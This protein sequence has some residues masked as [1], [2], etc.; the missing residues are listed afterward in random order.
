MRQKYTALEL[1]EEGNLMEPANLENTERYGDKKDGQKSLIELAGKETLYILKSLHEGKLNKNT[2]K[3]EYQYNELGFKKL[4]D[5]R[6]TWTNTVRAIGGIQDAQEQYDKLVEESKTNAQIKQ[7]VDTKIANPENSTNQYEFQAT[8]AI[9]QDFSKSRIPYIQLTVF[10]T[11]IGEKEVPDGYYGTKLIDVFEYSTA[12]TDASNDVFNVIRK[13]QE[14]FKASTTNLY[15][16]RIGR[17]NIPTLNLQK[18]VDAFGI[19]GKLDTSNSFAFARAIGFYLDD[20]AIIKN[21]LKKDTKTIEQ[22]GL[23]YI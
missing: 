4:A 11:K 12:V 16:D 14:N 18:V 10:K 22:F 19:N 2:N 17:D 5:F 21:T 6:T 20:I 15:V 8:S 23:P 13:F 3:I 1:D 9:W 7:L